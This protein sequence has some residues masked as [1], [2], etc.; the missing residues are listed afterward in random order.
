MIFLIIL[1]F[2]SSQAMALDFQAF[3]NI[4]AAMN[5]LDERDVEYAS[6]ENHPNVT[7]LSR[8]GLNA[9]TSPDK[10][11]NIMG[12]VLFE[13]TNQLLLDLLHV[14]RDIDNGMF[15]KV[16]KQRLPWLLLSEHVQVD[17]LLPWT[18]RPDEVYG[19]VPFQSFTGI[20]LEKQW[21]QFNL[22]GYVGESKEVITTQ[23]TGTDYDVHISDL[24]GARLEFQH[25]NLLKIFASYSRFNGEVDVNTRIDG[26]T[27]GTTIG[28]GFSDDLER[29]ELQTLGF[30]LNYEDSFL[31]SEYLNGKSQ[32]DI[33]TRTESAYVALGHTFAEKY[34]P[35][36]QVSSD[37]EVESELFPSKTTTY[38][39]GLLYHYNESS[40]IKFGYS[41]VDFRLVT[42]NSSLT[43]PTSNISFVSSGL[44]DEDFDVYNIQWAFIF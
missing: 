13:G 1:S 41:H 27:A 3:G 26:T 43:P 21:K 12:Q 7:S 17:A 44:I 11:T 10:N 14:K 23:N 15:I 4:R 36:I 39:A 30:Q 42:V 33:L 31:M 32:S 22:T 6:T 8:F 28:Y 16:G 5:T 34:Q 29:Y 24:Y 40:V 37:L 38:A 2:L 20:S 19:K 18:T 9:S 25:A 35:I